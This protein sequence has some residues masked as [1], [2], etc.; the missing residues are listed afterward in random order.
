[1][2]PVALEVAL[3]VQREIQARFE[4]A[5]RL[6]RLEVE[7]AVMRLSSAAAAS[8]ALAYRAAGAGWRFQLLRKK[9][10]NS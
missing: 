7:R 9:K 10:A 5:D 8:C 3:N 2:T 4:G 6:R 1:M